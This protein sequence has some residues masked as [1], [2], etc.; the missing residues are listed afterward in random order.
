M[1]TLRHFFV[2]CTLYAAQTHAQIYGEQYYQH[3]NSYI[4]SAQ[5]V[6][7]LTGF[8][9][10]GYTPFSTS[11]G[12]LPDF[13]IDKTDNFMGFSMPI[14]DFSKQYEIYDGVNCGSPSRVFNCWGVSI[15]QIGNL[16]NGERYA[17]TGSYNRGV[18]FAT[19]GTSGNVINTYRWTFGT[20]SG[21]GTY[22]QPMLRESAVL[23]RYYIC[24]DYNGQSYV[25][26]VNATGGITP[27]WSRWYSSG[28]RLI[29]R[30]VIE[31]VYSTNEVVVVGRVDLPNS[32]TAADAFFMRLNASN[33]NLAAAPLY[34]NRQFDGDD[35]ISCI[36]VANDPAYQGYLVGGHSRF[37][38]TSAGGSG[39]TEYSQWMAKL[40][41]NGNPYW[42]T[43]ILPTANTPNMPSGTEI[44]DVYE[45]NNQ[46]AYE[47]YGAAASYV[48]PG[49]TLQNNIVVYKLDANGSITLS[50]DEFH[51]L[52]GV[53]TLP[54]TGQLYTKVQL[55]AI[56]NSTNGLDDGFQVYGTNPTTD[57]YFSKAYFNGVTG[58]STQDDILRDFKGPTVIGSFAVNTSPFNTNC[59]NAFYLN[60]IPVTPVTSQICPLQSSV[61]G[62]S[63]LRKASTGLTS[64][65]QR[66]VVE[67]FPNPV[68]NKASI[69]YTGSNT[70]QATIAIY[71][72]LGQ[73]V[74]A[75]VYY[76]GNGQAE[77]DLSAT[78]AAS[79]VYF[80]DVTT[81]DITTRVKFIYTKE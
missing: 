19:L 10:A 45:R 4:S 67:V 24:G 70:E 43:L 28:F 23:G 75:A 50:P 35:W 34:Y 81:N 29:A 44:T 13:T 66:P 36:Q 2:V 63:N 61:P 1:K 27:I 12:P 79:G 64:N 54:I 6:Q 62:G 55:T 33:G 20:S 32:T 9:M 17:I 14:S 57:H 11:A 74:N 7:P 71:N 15:I 8:V 16:G 41:P 60:V 39:N 65:A 22:G 37:P 25:I 3:T 49:G 30:D 59:P 48:I 72:M 5:V 76:S 77:I 42:T 68:S 47:N 78:T 31:S 21:G 18:F 52:N 58:C 38:F 26:K 51:Y 69:R 53:G 46:G 80:A 56:D 73:N 40:D